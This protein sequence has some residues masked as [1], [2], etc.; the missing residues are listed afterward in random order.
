MTN[1]FKDIDNIALSFAQS[2]ATQNYDSKELSQKA[3]QM[4]LEWIDQTKERQK[5][6]NQRYPS[7]QVLDQNCDYKFVEGKKYWVA[8]LSHSGEKETVDYIEFHE[9]LKNH[10][11]SPFVF[12]G[13][14]TCTTIGHCFIT[15]EESECFSDDFK[16]LG[17]IQSGYIEEQRNRN[18]QKYSIDPGT[19]AGA[20]AV[21]K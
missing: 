3:I 5:F 21:Q 17:P 10:D 11:P 4:A 16:P 8:H 1:S 20:F 14:D 6:Y 18:R 9:K 12:I 2:L 15:P 7:W 13:R 19:L